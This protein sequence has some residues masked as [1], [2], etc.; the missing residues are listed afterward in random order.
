MLSVPLP[1]H[2]KSSYKE[3]RAIAEEK[4]FHF[5]LKRWVKNVYNESLEI[6]FAQFMDLDRYERHSEREDYRN[7][8]YER[9]LDTVY[10]YIDGLRVPRTRKGTFQ[11]TVFERY[12]RRESTINKLIVEC[13]WRG[14]STRDVGAVLNALSGCHISASTVSR[15]TAEWQQETMRWHQR[16]ITDD[17]VYL[18]FDGVWIKNR[19]LGQTKRLVL[20]AYGVK[21]D[22]TK[23]IIDYMLSQTEKEEHWQKFLNFLKHRGLEGKHIKLIATDGCHGLW[24][25][26]DMVYP[27]VPH[28]VCWAHKMRNI[29]DKVK[30]DDKASVHKGLAKIFRKSVKT[31]Q[32]AMT[33]VV[34]WKR[35]WRK[36]YPAA[37]AS[38]EA[39]E[40]RLFT[41]FDCP[42]EH[43]KAIRTTNHIERN[44]RE[45]RRRM[46]PMEVIPNVH[47]ADRIL[48]ALVQ[49]RNVKLKN[50]PLEF[51]QN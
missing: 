40:E 36:K 10:G 24:N 21:K 19:S 38:L 50:Y 3:M 29:L 27:G 31:R 39:A 41:Y 11:P 2:L 5:D 51:T 23:E 26:I 32:Q 47:S 20:V 18:F 28:Q 37:V 48:Y 22:G 44:F 17:Y 14:I 15:L 43:H 16:K 33:I 25:A 9:S 35:E 13:Y 8:F 7:G 6:E 30:K 45:F 46:R 49:I 42:R 12:K 1:N 34:K 4:V